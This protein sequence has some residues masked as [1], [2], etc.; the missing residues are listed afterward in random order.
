L[1]AGAGAGC[2]CS[3]RTEAAAGG[4]RLVLGVD[5]GC[6]FWASRALL[7][8][9]DPARMSL[10]CCGGGAKGSSSSSST[11]EGLL[12]PIVAEDELRLWNEN[13]KCHCHHSIESIT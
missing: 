10:C 1:A 8:V 12:V 13:Q 5:K 2:C 11:S 6:A 9:V 7:S 4:L 3:C